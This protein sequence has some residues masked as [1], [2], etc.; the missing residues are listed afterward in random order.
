MKLIEKIKKL[1]LNV[2]KLQKL[3]EDLIEKHLANKNKINKMERK[4]HNLKKGIEESANEIEEFMKD[5]DANI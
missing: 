3:N 4:I 1:R 2:N 5:Q